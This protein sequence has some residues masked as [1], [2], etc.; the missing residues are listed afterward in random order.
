MMC[1]CLSKRYCFACLGLILFLKDYVQVFGEHSFN[2]DLVSNRLII[3]QCYSTSH[4]E[5]SSVARIVM[6]YAQVTHTVRLRGKL[7]DRP[8]DF[9]HHPS[10]SNLASSRPNPPAK[11]GGAC[12]KTP[13]G[14]PSAYLSRNGYP[15]PTCDPRIAC[16]YTHRGHRARLAGA[17]PH[18]RRGR[19]RHRA[20]AAPRASCRL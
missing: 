3:R 11:A 5:D 6:S 18:S 7:L 14:T 8:S 9:N 1:L 10:P 4:S 13:A 15:T 12:S 16:R 2:S 19:G 20:C 17:P